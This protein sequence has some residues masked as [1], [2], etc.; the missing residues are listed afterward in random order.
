[1]KN[2]YFYGGFLVVDAAVKIGGAGAEQTLHIG[3]HPEI[4]VVGARD[5]GLKAVWVN[6]NGDEWPDHLQR[7]DG[8]VKDVG[9]LLSVLGVTTR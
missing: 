2:P 4:D 7:P 9:E 8:I 6:R 1:M 3:D 5:A